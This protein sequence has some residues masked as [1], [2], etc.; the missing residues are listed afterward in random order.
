MSP[1]KALATRTWGWSI[2]CS[3]SISGQRRQAGLLQRLSRWAPMRTRRPHPSTPPP[4]SFPLRAGENEGESPP[5]GRVGL[6]VT[7]ITSPGGA[8]RPV[9]CQSGTLVS[10]SI[11]C[12]TRLTS[13]GT[14]PGNAVAAGWTLIFSGGAYAISRSCRVRTKRANGS[15]RVRGFLGVGMTS[16]AWLWCQRRSW[17]SNPTIPLFLPACEGKR[18]WVPTRGEGWEGVNGRARMARETT[19]TACTTSLSCN[20]VC[21]S[22]YANSDSSARAA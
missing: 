11:R 2:G 21:W 13:A 19:C 18:R 15:F 17:D 20:P 10:T 3:W 16:V 22:A 14:A 12:V 8:Y 9:L 4:P 6:T 7:L 5:V 1:P